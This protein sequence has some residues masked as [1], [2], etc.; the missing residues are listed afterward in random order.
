MEDV[1]AVMFV[2]SAYRI[3]SVYAVVELVGHDFAFVFRS[4]MYVVP[5]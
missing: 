4:L 3:V 2:F 5:F 1:L